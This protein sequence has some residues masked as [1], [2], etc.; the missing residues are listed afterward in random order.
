M[1][2]EYEATPKMPKINFRASFKEGWKKGWE[3]ERAK[4]AAAQT[5]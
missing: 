1:R 3:G 5:V 2:S 4:H